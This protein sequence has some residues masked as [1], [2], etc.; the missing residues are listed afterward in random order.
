MYTEKAGDPASLITQPYDKIDPALQREYYAKS[1]YNYCRIILPIENNRY[2][3]AQR[4]IQNWLSENI[5]RKEEK[6]AVFV[7]KQDFKLSGKSYSRTGLIAALRLYPYGEN[8]VFPHEITYSEPK[9][10]RLNMLRAVEKDLEPVFLIYSDPENLAADFFAEITKTKPAFEVEDSLG[11]KHSIWKVTKPQ[12]IYLLRK[13]MEN[14][15][16]VI[17][18]G[19]HRYESAIA[20]RDEKRKKVSWTEDSAFNFHMCYMVPVQDEGLTVLPTYRLLKHFEL[21]RESWLALNEMFAVK[22]IASNIE[23]LEGFL[24]VH[25]KEHAF[26]IYDGKKAHGLILKD[27]NTAAKLVNYDFP[28]E[29]C[30]LDVVILRDVIF[31]H[32]MKLGELRMDENIFYAGSISSALKKVDS[33]QAK[34]A[35]LVNSISPETVWQI[36]QKNWRL[37]E[38]STDFYPKPVSGLLMMDIAPEEK[39]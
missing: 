18:D 38:K 9:T 33:G 8:M 16:L 10:D 23:R 39:L 6:A 25:S 32:I 5:L 27:E 34:V 4:R 1:V 24:S 15:K 31:K 36:A 21:T 3:T 29:A 2:E 7:S 11:V 13:A 30:L 26:V 20:Y 14:K 12:K 22:E 19:H 28:K 17:T 35:F 37:P